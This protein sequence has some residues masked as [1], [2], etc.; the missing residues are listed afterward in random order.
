[1]GPDDM[2][3]AFGFEHQRPLREDTHRMTGGAPQRIDVPDPSELE[4]VTRENP[5]DPE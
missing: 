3:R 1:M 5:I 2:R 4:T